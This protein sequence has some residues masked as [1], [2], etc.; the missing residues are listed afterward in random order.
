MRFLDDLLSELLRLA[1]GVIGA[2][3]STVLVY[4][5]AMHMLAGVAASATK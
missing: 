3:V 4:W 1:V 2:I 5:V